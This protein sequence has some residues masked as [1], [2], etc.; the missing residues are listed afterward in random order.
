LYAK[1]AQKNNWVDNVRVIFFGPFE[2]L[3]CEDEDVI[4]AASELLDFQTPIACKFL[5]DKSGAS[6][7]L[8][9]LGFNVEYVGALISD[10]IKAGY[11]PMVF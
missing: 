1:N 2:N 11:I 8:E 10:S 6:G 3:V 9:E 5:S 4:Q 7:K